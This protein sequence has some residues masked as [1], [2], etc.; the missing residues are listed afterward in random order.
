VFLALL[1]VLVVVVD[2][3]DVVVVVV[4]VVSREMI[5]V[6]VMVARVRTFGA[7][8]TPTIGWGVPE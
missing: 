4:V 6:L 2:V 3:V 7:C 1:F 8:W 5:W